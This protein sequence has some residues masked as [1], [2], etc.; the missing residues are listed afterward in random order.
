MTLC[1]DSEQ[2]LQASYNEDLRLARADK[3]SLDNDKR[4]YEEQLVLYQQRYNDQE[5]ILS[6]ELA[7]TVL[8]RCLQDCE[9]CV[10]L[11]QSCQFVVDSRSCT[12]CANV[13]TLCTGHLD[14]GDIALM[15]AATVSLTEEMGEIS[16][17]NVADS[18]GSRSY[19][20][21]FQTAD[22]K[23]MSYRPDSAT[24]QPAL[25]QAYEGFCD[26]RQFLE[27]DRV[28]DLQHDARYL[29]LWLIRRILETCYLDLVAWWM[30]HDFEVENLT[31]SPVHDLPDAE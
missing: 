15:E 16:L 29:E 2:G 12:A 3:A 24:S 9:R 10:R 19:L 23:T 30:D 27:K 22:G 14:Y 20:T 1:Q 11:E 31:R 25:V 13:T 17:D 4:R 21:H 28:R 8:D 6:Q 7:N 26:A 18:F 5:D